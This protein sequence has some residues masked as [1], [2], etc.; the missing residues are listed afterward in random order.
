MSQLSL[1]LIFFLLASHGLIP[2][3]KELVAFSQA[4]M[5][6]IATSVLVT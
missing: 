5:A 6:G 4:D 1:H 3:C 2:S